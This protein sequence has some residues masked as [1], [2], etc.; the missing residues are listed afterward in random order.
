MPMEPLLIHLSPHLKRK[1]MHLKS[2][3]YTAS[4]FIR[5]VLERELAN[6]PDVPS[7]A[8]KPKQPRTRTRARGTRR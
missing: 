2:S 4:G 1:L 6:V 8:P 3:G 5:A 7:V